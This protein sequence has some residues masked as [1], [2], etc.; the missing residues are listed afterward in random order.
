M[1]NTNANVALDAQPSRPHALRPQPISHFFLVGS[2][3]SGSTMLRMML[4]HH[5]HLSC[6]VEC[7]F[8][9]RHYERC[10]RAPVSKYDQ[11]LGRD[12]SFADSGLQFPTGCGT[13]QQVVDA[14]FHQRSQAT[15]KR[16]VG[17][18]IHHDFHHLPQLLPQ[19]KYYREQ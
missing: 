16:T 3:R 1:P 8:M 14:F 4:D 2:V 17:A 10:H 7:P 15:G 18:T 5:P 12:H 6:M 19:A 13:Y 9:V 11:L